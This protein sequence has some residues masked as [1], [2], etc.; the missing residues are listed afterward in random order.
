MYF[1]SISFV[2]CIFLQK[3]GV[4]C[5]AL[6]NNYL[7]PYQLP[8]SLGMLLVHS[9]NIGK[10][11]TILKKNICK[12]RKDHLNYVCTMTIVISLFIH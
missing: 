4:I 5:M 7:I 8:I 1:T 2:N 10:I 3:S 6:S 9:V 12:L 11:Y